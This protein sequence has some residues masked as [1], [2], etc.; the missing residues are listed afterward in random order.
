MS[1]KKLRPYQ[2]QAVQEL[3][4]HNRGICVLPT[5]AGKTTIFIEDVKQRM[6]SASHPLVIVVVAP[7]IL[8]CNQLHF[9]FEETLKE[10]VDFFTILVHSGE[11]GVTNPEELKI[12]SNL[13]KKINRHQILF[14]TYKSLSRIHEA[15][16]EIDIA[17]FD[18]AH[19][20]TTESNFVGVAQTSE[21]AKKIYFFTATPKDTK[22]TKS[23][24]N[25]D[26]YGGT[27]YT[28]SPKELVE[29]GY[30]L[31][32]KLESYEASLDD[33]DNVLNFLSSLNGNPKVLVASH[34]TK[35]MIEMFT[36]TDLLVELKAMGYNVLHITSKLGSIVNN[37]KV[38]RPIFFETLN[39]LCND[40]NEKVIIFHVVILSEG[41]S[42]PGIS[43]VLMLRNLNIIE[44]VQTIGRVL[45]LHKEDIQRIQDGEVQSGDFKNY[46][47]SCGIIAVPIND[48]RGD[49]ILQKLQSVIDTLFIEGKYL[50]A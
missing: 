8:L 2:T 1:M 7:K 14:T 16:I 22:D 47:K 39:R 41:I 34:S 18:E 19:H 40:E 20:S 21:L 36:E 29:G 13:A 4:K 42:V 10:Q 25:S 24:L 9:E 45:R 17:I 6:L 43:H 38:S 32:P 46:K 23:M 3:Q 5:S 28:L 33:S 37:Q 30:I 12:Y 11:D 49:R 31:P 35:S 44:M 15:N 27:I 26:V 48:K 50:I